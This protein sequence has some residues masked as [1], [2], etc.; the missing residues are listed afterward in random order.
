MKSLIRSREFWLAVV[1]AAMVFA[2]NLRAPG[3]ASPDRL[4][5]VFNDSAMLMILA[6]GQMAVILS[7][8]IDLS[9][10]SNL[11]LSGMIVALTNAAFPW[12]PVPA[13]MVLAAFCGLILGAFNGVLVWLLCRPALSLRNC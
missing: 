4:A 13:L 5:G 10:A 7:R 9:M 8:S 3:F 6:L 2:T 1:I 12:V 11:A